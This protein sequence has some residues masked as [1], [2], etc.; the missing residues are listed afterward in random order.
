M[1]LVH[2]YALHLPAAAISSQQ[3]GEETVVNDEC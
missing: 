2:I 1:I 3:I